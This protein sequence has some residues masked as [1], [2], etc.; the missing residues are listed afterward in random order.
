MHT[1]G[2]LICVALI[3]AEYVALVLFLVT[4]T[5]ARTGKPN[6]RAKVS[7]FTMACMVCVLV[8]IGFV[9]I[10]GASF[11]VINRVN[12]LLVALA[13]APVV[14]QQALIRRHSRSNT[15]S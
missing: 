1:F 5:P 14:A 3:V 12:L 15:D 9:M 2:Y 6:K 4:R 8:F 10:A 13:A 7:R 11:D